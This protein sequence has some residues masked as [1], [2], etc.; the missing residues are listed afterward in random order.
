MGRVG[1]KGVCV[2]YFVAAKPINKKRKNNLLKEGG[3]GDKESHC[4]ND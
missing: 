3:G 1:E 2:R 4:G